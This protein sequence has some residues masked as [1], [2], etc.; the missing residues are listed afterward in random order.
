MCIRSIRITLKISWKSRK[1]RAGNYLAVRTNI[2]FVE[3]KLSES[4]VGINTV[5]GRPRSRAWW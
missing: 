2:V 3:F 1:M 4:H 5:Y